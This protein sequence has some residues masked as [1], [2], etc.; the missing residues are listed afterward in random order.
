MQRWSNTV[1]REDPHLQTK[2]GK[3]ILSNTRRYHCFCMLHSSEIELL[4]DINTISFAYTC[5]QLWGRVMGKQPPTWYGS[6]SFHTYPLI[7]FFSTVLWFVWSYIV[8]WWVQSKHA[9]SHSIPTQM[10]TVHLLD[11]H[12]T[13]VCT[14]YMQSTPN[15][16]SRPIMIFVPICKY[17]A[18]V[19]YTE[20]KHLEVFS[21]LEWYILWHYIN[22]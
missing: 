11:G 8:R 2:T 22:R 17:T 5:M 6:L 16:S 21:W 4:S 19:W 12:R 3:S 18:V 7:S 13:T 20:T 9:N 1:L 10:H 15:W 14:R